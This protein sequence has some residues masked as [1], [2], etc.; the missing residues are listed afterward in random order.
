[1]PPLLLPV[2][3]SALS[4]FDRVVDVRD[5]RE[6]DTNSR[7]SER[8]LSET[9]AVTYQL[10]DRRLLRTSFDD[11]ITIFADR[12]L[13][14]MLITLST[15]RFANQAYV[16][17]AGI[18]SFCFTVM[19]HG[20]AS[21]VQGESETIAAGTNG[22]AFRLSAGTRALFSDSN[23]RENLWIK[24]PALEHALEGMLGDRLRKPLEFTPS[25]D[26]TSGLAASLRSQIDFITREITR[27]DGVA[28]NPV[29]L[30][31]LTD[32]I[33]SLVLR[34]IRHNYQE[35]LDNRRRFSVVPAYVRRAEDFMHANAAAPI[36]MEQVAN[37]AGC[38]VRT[39]GA[40]FRRFRDTAPL[41]ALHVIRLEQ[42]QAE[43]SHGAT[44]GSVAEVARRYGFTNPGRLTAA[45]RRRFGEAPLETAAR[46]SR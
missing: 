37:A 9:A 11:P 36:R 2:D 16:G 22:L 27:W 38:S 24:A 19:F 34:G 14:S 3:F 1:M 15:D 30:T 23:A 7:V 41:A 5:P 44:S 12:R 43:L 25:V 20:K 40:V 32:L 21:L 33:L 26:W 45:Y 39:L 4:T 18:D 42:V 8:L 46:S 28:D 29:A 10:Q 13:G 6:M 31:S 35:R 17:G